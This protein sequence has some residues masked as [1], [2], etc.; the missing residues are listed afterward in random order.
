MTDCVPSAASPAGDAEGPEAGFSPMTQS[1]TPP[2]PSYLPACPSSVPWA[3]PAPSLNPRLAE[4][5]LLPIYAHSLG[6]LI[7]F[8]S[9]IAVSMLATPRFT[10]PGPSSE[11]Q[12]Q[13]PT[14]LYVSLLGCLDPNPEL[15]PSPLQA[16]QAKTH[17][18]IFGDFS[19]HPL[20]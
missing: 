19:F 1:V 10:S 15:L 6:D 9:L 12:T 13:V 11:L 5:L 4:P 18:L 8:R 16:A 2:L 3:S 7:Q 17:G 20:L 14:L